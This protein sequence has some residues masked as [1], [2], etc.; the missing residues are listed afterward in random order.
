MSL[1]TSAY[2]Q[3]LP[4]QQDACPWQQL[5]PQQLPGQQCAVFVQQAAPV[6]ASADRENSDM[7][8]TANIFDFIFECM[9]R[10]LSILWVNSFHAR[11]H[12][13]TPEHAQESRSADRL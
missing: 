7:A 8:T 13:G 5:A 9:I 1:V 4:G 6:N 2:L 10:F 12:A 3:Q 11:T